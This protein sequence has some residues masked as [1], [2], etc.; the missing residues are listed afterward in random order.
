MPFMPPL[1]EVKSWTKFITGLFWT[2]RSGDGLFSWWLLAL[3]WV[4][5]TAYFGQW[6]DFEMNFLILAFLV[7][8]A[9]H[10]RLASYFSL[11]GLA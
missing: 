3:S 4:P 9:M 2:N 1:F 10:G 6:I 11:A 7:W 8:V 5:G